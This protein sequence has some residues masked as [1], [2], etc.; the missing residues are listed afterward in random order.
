VFEKGTRGIREAL[1]IIEAAATNT[2]ETTTVKWDGKPAIIWG[3]KPTGE[4]VLTDK[5]GFLAKGYDGLATSSDQLARI[6]NMRSGERGELIGIYSKLWPMLETAT[7]ATA[8][9][10]RC[11]CVQAQLH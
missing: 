8:R 2:A 7:P 5:S 1:A 4:F 10:T 6:Q 9:G 11:L 3:R